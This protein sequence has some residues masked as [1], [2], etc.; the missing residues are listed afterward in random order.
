[1]AKSPLVVMLAIFSVPAEVLVNA[2]PLAAEVLS[3]ASLAK[4][5]EV[6]SATVIAPGANTYAAPCHLFEASLCQG[7]RR[8]PRYRHGDRC[9]KLGF[10]VPPSDAVSSACW[11][12]V[13]PLCT[14]TYAAPWAPL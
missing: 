2:T 12:H 3:R 5:T 4:F 1:M 6:G 11:L 9:A 13:V 10:S 14:N 7:A 8:R